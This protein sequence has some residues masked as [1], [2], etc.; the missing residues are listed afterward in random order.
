[1]SRERQLAKTPEREVD[2][3]EPWN[4]FRDMERMF[5]DFFNAPMT[6]WRNTRMWPGETFTTP[7]VDIKENDKELVLSAT[8]PGINKDD[9]DIDVTEDS[10]TINGE[11]KSIEEKPGET[12][13]IRQQSYGSFKVSYSL[14]AQVKPG[15]VA[16]TYKD[17][18]LEITMPKAE[19][20]Q[21]HKV[22]VEL[23]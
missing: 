15:E 23:K 3:I 13:H 14:P 22:K 17:G 1:M 8:V 6:N 9:I 7:A 19:V 5:R 20:T 2:I 16:A 11:R 10:I 18:I 21:A 4:T 12:Y